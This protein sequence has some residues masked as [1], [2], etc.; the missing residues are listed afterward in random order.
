[1]SHVPL[2]IHAKPSR[3]C[4][5]RHILQLIHKK[6]RAWQQA[7]S[8]PTDSNICR[9]KYAFFILLNTMKVFRLHKDYVAHSNVSVRHFYREASKRLSQPKDTFPL[10]DPSGVLINT[11]KEKAEAFNNAF[12]QNFASIPYTRPVPTFMQN[13]EANII[14]DLVSSHLRKFSN[15]SASPD[16][17]SNVFLCLAAP[18]L[19]IPLTTIFQCSVFEAKIPDAWRCTKVFPLYK[20]KGSKDDPNAYRP[21]SITSPVGKLLESFIKD[22][23]FSHIATN[24]PLFSSQHGFQPKKSSLINPICTNNFILNGIN[25]DMPVDVILLDFSRAFDKVP[26]H[27]L[28]DTLSAFGFSYRLIS[29]FADFLTNRTQ[30]V[31]VNSSKSTYKCVTSGVIQGS[32]LGQFLFSLFINSLPLVVSY[33]KFLLFADDRKIMGY[34]VEGSHERIVHDLNEV[35]AWSKRNC[36]PL[37]G[38]KCLV[39]HYN[40]RLRLNP[41]NNYMINGVLLSS[42]HVCSDL[43]VTCTDNGHYSEHIATICA[44]ASRRIGLA[45]CLFQCREP[46]FMLRLF[47][48]YIRPLIEY[49]A[50]IWSPTDVSS[51][52]KLERIQRRFI[53]RIRG[54]HNL[55]YEERL[56]R[57]KIPLLSCRRSFLLG[58]LIYKLIHNLID[59]PLIEAGLQLSTSRTRASGLKLV[60]PRPFCSLFHNSFIFRAVTLWNLLPYNIINCH[61][62]FAFRT[63]LYKH[64]SEI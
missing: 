34:V 62:F 53:K 38:D 5:P 41:C 61:S 55:L 6:K 22:L 11:D 4:L 21:I 19:V 8:N 14:Y 30:F 35:V 45:L 54:L 13:F 51:W 16:V 9:F 56:S 59:M 42:F 15:S 10:L 57:L 12:V 37:N 17:I 60:V 27:I 31:S 52:V 48:T 49:A 18:G 44:K 43:G 2:V 7:R 47:T 58:C 3:P 24:A 29:W 33:C 32:V 20:G 40:G 23:A 50:P 28:I 26:H 39:M 64:L 25:N 1:M 36:L 46:D 63:A